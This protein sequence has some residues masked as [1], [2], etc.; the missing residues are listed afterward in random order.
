MWR[1][2][3]E[4]ENGND[5]NMYVFALSI[6]TCIVELEYL[7]TWTRIVYSSL[8]S[9]MFFII[10]YSVLVHLSVTKHDTY[11]INRLVVMQ[12]KKKDVK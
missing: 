7:N 3:E 2:H 6:R 8:I 5:A 11:R 9:T 10:E 4:N 12:K 1:K